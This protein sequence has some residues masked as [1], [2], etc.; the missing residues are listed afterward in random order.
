MQFQEIS[1]AYSILSDQEKRDKYDRYGDDEELEGDVDMVS[2]CAVRAC[3]SF[4]VARV[5]TCLLC[6]VRGVEVHVSACGV[7]K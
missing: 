5:C 7:R 6:S 2:G 1:H 4:A 3:V